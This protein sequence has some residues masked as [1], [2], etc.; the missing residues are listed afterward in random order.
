MNRPTCK[1]PGCGGAITDKT[2]S[3][4]CK[5]HRGP[6]THGIKPSVRFF[7]EDLPR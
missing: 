5:D 6:S 7:A 4:F 1:S 3:K 2:R